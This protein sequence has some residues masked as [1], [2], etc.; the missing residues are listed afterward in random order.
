MLGIRLYHPSAISLTYILVE[1][2]SVIDRSQRRTQWYEDVPQILLAAGR[3]IV[4]SSCLH[5]ANI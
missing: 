5:R 2:S 3:A 4:L 1:A